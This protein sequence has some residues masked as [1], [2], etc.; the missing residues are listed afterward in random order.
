MKFICEFIDGHYFLKFKENV[1]LMI[2]EAEMNEFVDCLVDGQEKRQ[3][4]IKSAKKRRSPVIKKA[5]AK[6]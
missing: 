4:A 2:E 3:K 5:K 6:K 1:V